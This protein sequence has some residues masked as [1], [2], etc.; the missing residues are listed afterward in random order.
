MRSLTSFLFLATILVVVTHSSELA[1]TFPRR[2]A[3]NDGLLN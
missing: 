2:M 3:M 1:R